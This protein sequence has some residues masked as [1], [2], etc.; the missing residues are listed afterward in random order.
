MDCNITGSNP[1]MPCNGSTSC[2]CFTLL[3]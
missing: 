1:P 2:T 3:F